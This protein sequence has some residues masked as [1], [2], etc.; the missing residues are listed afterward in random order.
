MSKF[1]TP[2]FAALIL[3]GASQAIAA[4]SVDLN[5]TGVITPSACEPNLSNGGVYDLGKI[6]A[7]DL[8]VDQPTRLP[9]HRLQLTITCAAPTLL[10]L[11]P[12]DNRAGSAYTG[13]SVRFGLGL[14][15]GGT[16]LG[17]MSLR[18]ESILDNGTRVYPIGSDTSATWAPT[19]LLSHMFLT[20]FAATPKILTPTPIQ[21]VIADLSITPNIAPAN[22]LPL[23]QEVPIDG[24]MTLTMRYL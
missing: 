1:T 19:D 13:S 4:S 15:D 6:A 10:A 24:S 22:T 9:T 18:L 14:I 21:Q 5:I 17:Y 20:S 16:R 23:T 2:L 3:V 7:K 11:A 12:S 8:N